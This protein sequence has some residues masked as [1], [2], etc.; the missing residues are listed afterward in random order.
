MAGPEQPF[1]TSDATMDA[2]ADHVSRGKVEL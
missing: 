1:A 2:F